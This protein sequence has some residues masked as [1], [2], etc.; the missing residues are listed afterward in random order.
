MELTKVRIVYGCTYYDQLH[1]RWKHFV[2][3]S[4]PSDAA[5]DPIASWTSSNA[6][7]VIVRFALLRV[8]KIFSAQVWQPLAR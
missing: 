6:I 7:R 1:D 8:Q 2:E 5:N 3:L 4:F